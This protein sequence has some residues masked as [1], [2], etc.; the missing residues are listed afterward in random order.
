MRA[1]LFALASISVKARQALTLFNFVP[2]VLIYGL[3]MAR[4]H[5]LNFFGAETPDAI[6]AAIF[7]ISYFFA[8]FQVAR[9]D[10]TVRARS[11][12]ISTG[13]TH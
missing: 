5:E 12:A 6:A 2:Q 7:V 8:L 4:A 3:L 1:T 10:A 13:C 11:G 9:H